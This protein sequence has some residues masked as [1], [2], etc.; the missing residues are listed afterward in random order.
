MKI[1]YP[2]YKIFVITEFQRLK[3]L[4]KED[5]KLQDSWRFD[6]NNL[7]KVSSMAKEHAIVHILMHG[8]Q[9]SNI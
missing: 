9:L 1:S 4:K 3:L 7:G 2:M 6:E 8:V 5:K